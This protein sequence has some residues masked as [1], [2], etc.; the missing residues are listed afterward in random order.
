MNGKVERM[1][2]T[3]QRW[4]EIHT[5]ANLEQLQER[6]DF[7]ADIQRKV[8]KVSRLGNSTRMLV[9]HEL[10]TAQRPWLPNSKEHFSEMRVYNFLTKKIYS[11]KVSSNGQ[12]NH[13]GHK[14][15]IGKSYK[16]RFIQIKLN[17]DSL[18]VSWS[19]SHDAKVIKA[20]PALH[21]DKDRILNL[22]VFQ[23]TK[24]T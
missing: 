22:S 21:L 11:R 15:S 16:G 6:L 7:E 4:A 18:P 1:Q 5:A 14:I 17:I 10:L 8:F 20:F 13:F 19:I 24:T 3:S 12:I 2:D 23:R 9:F